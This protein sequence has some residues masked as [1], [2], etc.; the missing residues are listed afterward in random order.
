MMLWEPLTRQ[1][2][3]TSGP[4]NNPRNSG[5]IS[6]QSMAFSNS[7]YGFQNKVRSLTGELNSNFGSKISNKFLASYT[8]IQDTRTSNS[9]LFPFVDIWQGGDQYM[10]FGY[11][12]FSYNN[13]VQNKT[14]SFTDNVTINLNK[15]TVTTGIA[16]DRL[17]FRNSYIREGTS[18]YRYSSVDNFI[19]DATPSGFGVTYGYN[20]E[21]A[22]GAEAT[23]GLGALYAQ[24]EWEVIPRLKITY[25][26]RLEKPFYFD[27]LEDNPSISALTFAE[28][29]KMD[30]GS[31][32]KS[33]MIVSPRF[34]FNYDVRGD[35]SLQIRGGSGVFTGL[36]PFVW[37]T[38]QPTNS[39][40]IQVPEIGWGTQGGAANLTGMTFNPDYKAVIASDPA[41]FPQTP[42]ILPSN[43]S[44]AQVGKNFKLPQIWRSN[45]GIDVELPYNM[46]FTAEGIFSKDIN[47]VVQQNINEAPYTG[48][49]TGPDSRPFWTSSTIAKVNSS[50]SNA[51]E[52]T[53][54][55]EGYQY[56]LTAQL[57]KNFSNGLS[58]MF[59]YTYTEARDLTS[60]PGSSASSAWSSNTAVGSLNDPGLSYSNFATPH[61]LIGSISY[62]IEYGNN[63]ATTL[64]LVYQG[65]QTGRWS[66]T[67]SNDLNGDGNSS[68]LMY[69]PASE[70]ELTFG[71]ATGFTVTPA[72]QQ[73]AFWNY[74]N[75][76][77]YLSE[78]KGQY[79][80]RF[81]HVQPWIHR[82]DVK[83]LQ[84]I[85]TDFGTTHKYTL[86]LSIDILN[87]GNMINDSWGTY[88]YNPLA[89]FENVRPLTVIT[90][91]T[92]TQAPVYRLN[93]T[94][95]DDFTT[96]TTLSKS[97]S[98]S[99]TWGCLLGLRLIF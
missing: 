82:F 75:N 73:A 16:F 98:T 27:D 45:L 62:R 90:R 84:D 15:H 67:Y 56:S 42:G 72:E 83:L 44:L 43:A 94:S 54:A 50:I 40:M 76:N 55:N 91:G 65:Y 41:R 80:E 33:S 28:G 30:V 13:D 5:R 20:G 58:G 12:L 19:N 63:F 78:H 96:K 95:L 38:N 49:M 99:S 88:S 35:R 59:A 47:A 18:Y 8:F 17:W 66:Y 97:I 1:T 3:A 74:I 93:A 37:F 9:D 85:F 57:T 32:P 51:M 22:P 71:T 46:V 64:S 92:A 87:A 89:S 61:K 26:V 11:E 4:P 31:W 70:T 10:S 24:D 25:G 60:N 6:N 68:D 2:N 7:F 52:L 39:G 34:G 23:F 36:L 21:D 77:E 48:S 29:K 86:Q 14:L 81:G 79:A 69:I 53:N